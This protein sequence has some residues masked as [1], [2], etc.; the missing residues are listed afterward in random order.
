MVGG[1]EFLVTC[2]ENNFI[3]SSKSHLGREMVTVY[4]YFLDD[5]VIDNEAVITK[6][7]DGKVE[8]SYYRYEIHPVGY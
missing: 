4:F 2:D 3:I 8:I 6:M 1:A 5:I 7:A